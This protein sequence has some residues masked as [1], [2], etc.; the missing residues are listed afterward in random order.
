MQRTTPR[1]SDERGIAL[2]VAVFA[3]VVIG[4]LVAGTFFVGRLEQ[5]SGRN[6]A[7]AG[8]A[9]EAAEGGLAYG[10]INWDPTYAD[11]AVYD[12]TAA[13]EISLGT[14]Q[15]GGNARLVATDTLR[16]LNS[17]LFL[18]RS[19]GQ[20]RGVGTQVLA[21]RTLA[22]VIRLSKP[23]IDVRSAIT[24]MDP[25]KFNGGAFSVSGVNS[26]PWGD[27]AAPRA[28][29]LDDLVG[30]RSATT[31]GVGNSD[32]DNIV[33]EPTSVVENDAQ[34]T[35]A[36]FQNFVNETFA[37]LGASA[38]VTLSLDTPYDPRPVVDAATNKCDKSLIGAGGGALNLGEPSRPPAN[39]AAVTQCYTYFPVVHG[40]AA[41]TKFAANARGQGTLLIDGDLEIAGGFEWAGLI[42][43]RGSFKITGNG[44]KITGSVMAEGLTGDNSIGGDVDIKYS[45]CAIERAVNGA[46]TPK[47]LSQR[48]WVNLYGL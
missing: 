2:A 47:P 3:M 24:V 35:P 42:I 13:S 16:R 19:V 46:A 48:S 30:I 25:I 38:D 20:R 33:G 44:N 22:Q 34:I 6:G 32:D 8:E 5:V 39:A 1:R 17:E 26:A 29:A 11:M 36:T 18:L 27:C 41:R 14:I 15:V 10:R 7:F 31:A 21:T 45:Q 9:A 23:I 28:D 40:T 4:A 37:S 12:G 43:V